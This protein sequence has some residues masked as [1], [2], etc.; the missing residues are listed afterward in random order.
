[1]TLALHTTVA[2]QHASG[3]P[4]DQVVN[5]FSFSR[6]TDWDAGALTALETALTD[7]YNG[8]DTGGTGRA[9]AE[10]IGPQISRTAAPVIRH[11]DLDG[12]LAGGRLGSPIRVTPMALLSAPMGGAPLPSEVAVCL[13]FHGAYGADPEFGA[14][15]TRPRQRDRGRIYVGP[16]PMNIAVVA[17]EASTSRPRVADGCADTLLHAANRLFLESTSGKTWCIWSR[18]NGVLKPITG[19]AVDD[20]FDTQ[21]RRGERPAGSRRLEF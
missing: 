12:H 4:R 2:L 21:R 16:M 9:V 11:Y 8:V 10:F 7:F 13:S 15:G 3:L 18:K 14:A 19:V 17:T 5:T 20:A 1:M 6:E